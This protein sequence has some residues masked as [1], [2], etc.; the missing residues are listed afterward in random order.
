MGKFLERLNPF[1]N[2]PKFSIEFETPQKEEWIRIVSE[3][4]E[5]IIDS[6]NKQTIELVFNE[7]LELKNF[8]PVHI[9]LLT[10]FIDEIKSKG[11]FIQLNIQNKALSDYLF[12]ELNLIT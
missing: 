8:Y 9:V 6:Q 3:C 12:N 5:R 11:Y 7:D 1:H 10:C 4:R 2:E